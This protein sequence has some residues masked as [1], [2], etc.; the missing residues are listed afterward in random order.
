MNRRQIDERMHLVLDGEATSTEAREL[1][2]AL[3]ADPDARA[4]FEDLQ[5]LF[6]DL[7]RVPEAQPPPGF[8]E[9]MAKFRSE[10]SNSRGSR[11]G[12]QATDHPNFR[13]GPFTRGN[14]AMSEQQNNTGSKRKVF[15]GTGIAAAV[16]V[17]LVGYFGTD[18][19]GTESAVG[20]IAPAQRYR[21]PQ[22]TAADVKIDSSSGTQ[23]AGTPT[24]SPSSQNAG[25]VN[26]GSANQG[27]ANQGSANQGSA[28]QGSANQGSANQGSANQGSANQGSANQGSANQGSANQGKVNQGSANQGSANQGSANQ[29]SANQGKVNQGSANQGSANQGR[30]TN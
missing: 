12:Q 2:S 11:P 7:R 15:I 21:A 28:N 30:A 14:E 24:S 1:E 10:M 26:Q 6:R 19:A 22:N 25:S 17:V 4:R 16:A 3:A 18:I 29:G 8:T 13:P 27:S 23:T 5:R 20:T 9:R